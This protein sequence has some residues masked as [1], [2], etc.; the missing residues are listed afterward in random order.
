MMRM[1]KVRS[2]TTGMRG[3]GPG[4]VVL[5][6]GRGLGRSMMVPA[7]EGVGTWISTL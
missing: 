7:W 1:D 2:S 3:I 4:I 6:R 5:S